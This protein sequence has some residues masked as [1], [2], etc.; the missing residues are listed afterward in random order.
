MCLAKYSGIRTRI[1]GFP[2]LHF[3][4]D[5]ELTEGLEKKKES[6]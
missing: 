6:E 2:Y 5:R 3:D 4:V 1:N